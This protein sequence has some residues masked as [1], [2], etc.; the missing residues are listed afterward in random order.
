[1]KAG[2]VGPEENTAKIMQIIGQ[3]F[4]QIEPYPYVYA[5]YTDVPRLLQGRQQQLD[6]LLFAGLTPLI[7]AEKHIR[8]LI[9]WE[10]IPRSGGSLL[11]A[12]LQI[13]L[14][15]KYTL[16]RVSIDVYD[17]Q[18][19]AEIFEEAGIAREQSRIYTIGKSPLDDD[20]LD[21]VCAFHERHYRAGRTD[22]CITALLNVHQRLS[23][24][25]IAC[26]L[27]KPTASIIRQTLHTLQLNHLVQVS[28]QSQIVAIYIRID[29]QDEYSLL[30]DDE[31]RYVID[32]TNVARHIYL[33]AQRVQAAVAEVGPGEFLLFSTRQ[34]LESVTEQFK[35][36]ALLREIEANT[37]STI[38]MGVGYGE[39][40]REARASA[41]LAM[42]KAA[43]LGGNMAF[44]VYN[45]NQ[46]VGPIRGAAGEAE[47]RNHKVDR[48]LLAVAEK[49]GICVNTLFRLQ[50]IL[51]LQG[52]A[53]FT[54]AE[55][56]SLA[57]VT[58]RTMN[59]LV[60]KL[61][62]H[63]YCFEVGKRV[64]ETAGRPSRIIEIR[65]AE[66]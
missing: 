24:A 26:F 34:L 49:A 65:F 5:A 62:L 20:Y 37:A 47:N 61:M 18:L 27:V 19:V 1:M 59:R 31:Y 17:R 38:S 44:I 39:T 50:T 53:R 22:Y 28:R 45:A 42:E 10:Y 57:G 55:L 63:G 14:E 54:T 52:R 15:K 2:I 13:A 60:E 32:K 3:E 46:L 6:A 8:R 30:R 36:I 43:K 4:P 58:P 23:A 7:Y 51:Q 33:F 48:Q 35:E 40:A 56:A 11:Q 41:V 9:P 66:R 16:C 25:G 12:L 64:L 29:S 21:Y